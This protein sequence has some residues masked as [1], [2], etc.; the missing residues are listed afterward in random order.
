MGKMSSE[1][2]SSVKMLGHKREAIFNN[3]YGNPTTQINW[4]GS[5][6]DCLIESKKLLATLD[7]SIGSQSN[8]VSVKGGSTIQIHLGKLPELTDR[9]KFNVTKNHKGQTV[10]DHG[11][12]FADQKAQLKSKDFWDTYLRKGDVIAWSI[13]DKGKFAFFNMDNIID[14]IIDN[15]NWRLLPTGRLKGDFFGK[16]YLTYEYRKKKDMFVLGAHGG[17]KG[18]EFINLL[19]NNISH[20]IQ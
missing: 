19:M 4:S 8:K 16:Q 20:H 5:S 9:A 18:K 17:K 14:F 10:V 13:D 6:A 1:L 3:L 15:C 2:A 11:I 7:Q 12:S